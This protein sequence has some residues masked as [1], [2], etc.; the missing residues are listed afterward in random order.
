[1]PLLSNS[2]SLSSVKLDKI[3]NTVEFS[4]LRFTEIL[5]R[6]LLTGVPLRY[7]K[8]C[9]WLSSMV[10]T[11]IPVRSDKASKDVEVRLLPERFSSSNPLA[12]AE[13]AAF[14]IVPSMLLSNFRLVRLWNVSNPDVNASPRSRFWPMSSTLINAPEP[15]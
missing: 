15:L 10:K 13:N 11:R 3:G 7:D 8:S 1:M 12:K 9:N 6:T 4:R 2:S 14:G 5:R